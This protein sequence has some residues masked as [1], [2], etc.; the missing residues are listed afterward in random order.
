MKSGLDSSCAKRMETS[1]QRR[2][3]QETDNSGQCTP[4]NNVRFEE[5]RTK[6]MGMMTEVLSTQ[7]PRQTVTLPA[8]VGAV[9]T[10]ERA[11][12]VWGKGRVTNTAI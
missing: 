1:V 12:P 4:T 2:D 9:W 7:I 8:E 11:P 3:T 6:L 5:G 10:I